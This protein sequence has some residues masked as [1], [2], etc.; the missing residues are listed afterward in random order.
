MS[1][2]IVF[3][4]VAVVLIL[5]GVSA[6][7][8][9]NQNQD[10]FSLTRSESK[11]IDDNQNKLIDL[12]I[13]TDVPIINDNGSGMLFDFLNDLMFSFNILQQLLSLQLLYKELSVAT[14]NA[15]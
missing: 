6:F 2:K 15:F 14:S 4:I 1:K 7:Y 5:G 9:F 3:V 12:S 10:N 13:L 11:W 8:F